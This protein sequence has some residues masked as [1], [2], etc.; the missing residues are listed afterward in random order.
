MADGELKKI[1]EDVSNLGALKSYLEN[2]NSPFVQNLA[3][4]ALKQLFT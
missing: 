4:S 2:S 3:A 1:T